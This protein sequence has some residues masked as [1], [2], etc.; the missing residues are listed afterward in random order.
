MYLIK[1]SLFFNVKDACNFGLVPPP[2]TFDN[3]P[4]QRLVCVHIVLGVSLSYAHFIAFSHHYVLFIHPSFDKNSTSTPH[5]Y[6]ILL[7][8]FSAHFLALVFLSFRPPAFRLR[9]WFFSELM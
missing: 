5:S 4:Q 9:H 3:L 2:V 1:V 6:S 7:H 8:V